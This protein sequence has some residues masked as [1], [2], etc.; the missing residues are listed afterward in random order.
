M[1]GLAYLIAAGIYLLIFVVIVLWAWRQ[2]RRASNARSW[3]FATLASFVVLLPLVY[4]YIPMLVMHKYYCDKDGGL[5]VHMDSSHWLREH[6]GDTASLRVRV[7]GQSVDP[8][9]LGWDSRY[10]INKSVAH[11]QRQVEFVIF[12]SVEFIRLETRLVDISTERVLST[13]VGYS[14][15]RSFQSG[16]LRPWVEVTGCQSDANKRFFILQKQLEMFDSEK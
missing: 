13:Y 6:E 1:I 12:P 9:P 3:G 2:G 5:T 10:L 11:D 4:D 7:G 8:P 14:A 16:N 15:G